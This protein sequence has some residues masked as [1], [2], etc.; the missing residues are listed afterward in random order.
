[1]TTVENAGKRIGE[2][3]RRRRR[4]RRR[5]EKAP[6][7]DRARRVAAED[8]MTAATARQAALLEELKQI[9]YTIYIY[10]CICIHVYIV[11]LSLYIC[12]YRL[13]LSPRPII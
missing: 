12:I 13:L 6:E 10:I 2:D 3:E 11:S 5:R 8:T 7:W 4:R 9:L 1:M